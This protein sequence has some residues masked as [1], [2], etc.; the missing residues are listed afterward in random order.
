[1]A[2][3]VGD[4]VEGV[5]TVLGADEQPTNRQPTERGTGSGWVDVE[6]REQVDKSSRRQ[7]LATPRPVVAEQ[8]QQEVLRRKADLEPRHVELTELGEPGCSFDARMR[9]PRLTLTAGDLDRPDS[10]PPR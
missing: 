3:P 5:A 7:R 1:M 9:P 10:S 4:S 6:L 2:K 8:R